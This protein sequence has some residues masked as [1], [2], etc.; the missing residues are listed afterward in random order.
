MTEATRSAAGP[1]LSEYEL[2]ACHG[3]RFK[4]IAGPVTVYA[5]TLAS[6]PD[7]ADL[8]S[9]PVC[10]MAVDPDECVARRMRNGV[11]ICFCSEECAAV[12]D[13]H[14]ERYAVQPAVAD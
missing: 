6:Q 3:R 12:F 13:Q 9:D 1:S 8:P 7:V 14:P 4:N 5:L 2:E 10:R 11:E